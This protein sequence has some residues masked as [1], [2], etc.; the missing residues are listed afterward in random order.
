MIWEVLNKL[1]NL[2]QIFDSYLDS[3]QIQNDEI[4]KALQEQNKKYLQ[5]IIEQNNQILELLNKE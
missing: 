1:S 4:M 5:I 3:K 2:V